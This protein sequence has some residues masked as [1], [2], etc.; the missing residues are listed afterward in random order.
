MEI[1]T[2]T[3]VFKE[4]HWNG[5]NDLKNIKWIKVNDLIKYLES[6]KIIIN[7]DMIPDEVN[8]SRGNRETI[9]KIITLINNSSN[10]HKENK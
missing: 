1:K 9:D 5:N 8:Y 7:Q 10:A 6:M 3:E 4:Y 2:S